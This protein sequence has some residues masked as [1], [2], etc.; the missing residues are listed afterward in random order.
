MATLEEAKRCP[1][2]NNVGK[3]NG[4]KPG[5]KPRTKVLVM[6]CENPLCRWH[7]TGWMIQINPD[8]SI[9]DP[10]DNP[11]GPKQFIIPRTEGE[12]NAIIESINAEAQQAY[13]ITHGELRGPS[14]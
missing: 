2:C 4:I 3:E 6:L 8:G 7:G 1:K 5:A 10:A 11:R 12:A 9:P 13:D 14:R